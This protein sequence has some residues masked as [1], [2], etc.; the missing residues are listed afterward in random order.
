M[1]PVAVVMVDEGPEHPLEIAAVEDQQPVETLGSDGADEPFGDRVGPRRS[2]RC[3]DDL[4][5]SLR[6]TMSKSR[7]N[8]LSRSLMRKRT[9]VD[10]SA[11]TQGEFKAE[12]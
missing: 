1:W 7:V 10:R 8:L 12:T 6:K 2:H 9:G 3:A 4:D 11:N 5:P